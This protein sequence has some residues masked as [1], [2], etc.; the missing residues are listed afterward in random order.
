MP[1][2]KTGK[3]GAV[4]C[5]GHSAVVSTES[6][7]DHQQ[8]KPECPFSLN[9]FSHTFLAIETTLFIA[10]PIILLKYQ[11]ATRL[12]IIPVVAKTIAARAPPIL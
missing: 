10:A 5:N 2:F 4:I 6:Q 1:N 8:E 9:S 7:T 3:L 12:S 11:K